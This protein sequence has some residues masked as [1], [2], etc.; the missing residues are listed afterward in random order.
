MTKVLSA[1]RLSKSSLTIVGLFIISVV[2]I[3]VEPRNAGVQLVRESLFPV[4]RWVTNVSLLPYNLGSG[5]ALWVKSQ[6]S[7]IR[8]NQLWMMEREYLSSQQQTLHSLVSENQ[9]L[10]EMLELT[11]VF[12]LP[13]QA[14]EVVQSD[15]LSGTITLNKG[16][17]DGVI[18]GAGVL[19]ILGV[20]GV[21]E[22]VTQHTSQVLLLNNPRHAVAVQSN[23]SGVRVM[24]SGAN[25]GTLLK[26]DHVPDTTD[27]EV[28]DVLVT[29]GLGERFPAGI[30]VATVAQIHRESGKPFALI[31]AVPREPVTKLSYVLIMQKE[32]NDA[33]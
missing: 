30:E 19:G 25:K 27:I 4:T 15:P 20:V 31:T 7:W 26:V 5:F 11:Q 3:I 1:S 24:V 16:T 32:R 18:E 29:S 21:I 6:N 9:R 2:M 12:P 8:Q 23:R 17:E 22:K 10:R 13:L 33:Q 14:A 28:G